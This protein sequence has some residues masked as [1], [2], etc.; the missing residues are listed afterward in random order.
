MNM[1]KPQSKNVPA[2]LVAISEQGL[3]IW[4]GYQIQFQCDLFELEGI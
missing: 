1:S 2:A 4:V 3:I